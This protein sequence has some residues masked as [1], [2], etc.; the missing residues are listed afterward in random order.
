MVYHTA[1]I[2]LA[3]PYIQSKGLAHSAADPLVQ[4]ATAIFLEAARAIPS[5]GDQYRLVFDSFRRSPITATYANL[6]AALALLSP[7]NQY[8]ARFNQ[9][10]NSKL[11]SCIQTLQE[12][13]TA[14]MPPGKYRCSLLKTIQNHPA[15]QQRETPTSSAL[16]DDHDDSQDSTSGAIRMSDSMQ[17]ANNLWDGPSVDNMGW[18]SWMSVPAGDSNMAEFLATAESLPSQPGSNVPWEQF[19]LSWFGSSLPEGFSSS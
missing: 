15:F 10:D 14:W 6:C 13:S 3:R 11:K 18:P 7:Q 4:K 1:V 2:L 12:L 5:L 19:D 9:A 8:R 16:T 17:P